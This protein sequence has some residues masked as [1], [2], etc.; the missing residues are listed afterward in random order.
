MYPDSQVLY[1]MPHFLLRTSV[2][3]MSGVTKR[4][5]VNP[6]GLS[7][8]C[9]TYPV[10]YECSDEP[11]DEWQTTTATN[12]GKINVLAW[13]PSRPFRTLNGRFRNL[14][15]QDRLPDRLIVNGVWRRAC[16]FFREPYIFFS[17]SS[18]DGRLSAW[19]CPLF[20]IICTALTLSAPQSHFHTIVFRRSEC[21]LKK[22]RNRQQCFR[23]T[24]WLV[25][26]LFLEDR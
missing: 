26:T 21:A 11:D 22:A 6:T 1:R 16:N 8:Y 7:C 15:R 14:S 10:V 12:K 17:C 9:R 25:A 13:F 20:L 24:S 18:F 19:C 2:E 23:W 4:T 5:T 3:L